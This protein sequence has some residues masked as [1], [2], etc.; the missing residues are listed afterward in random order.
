VVEAT[1]RQC[2]VIFDPHWKGSGTYARKICSVEC[3]RARVRARARG[4]VDRRTYRER[5]PEQV[6]TTQCSQCD[7]TFDQLP[8]VRR[9]RLTCSK[10]CRQE[11]HVARARAWHAANYARSNA[12]NDLARSV[13]LSPAGLRQLGFDI[14]R[15]RQLIAD[16]IRCGNC[17]TDAPPRSGSQPGICL[18]HDHQTGAFRGLLCNRCNL[19]LGFAGDTREGLLS[20]LAYL[21]RAYARTLT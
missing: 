17:G 14:T 7:R 5:H 20:L 13:C 2:G 21:D 10:E 19:A 6:I 15:L 18:D 8:N 3:Q 4:R 1:C 11:R 16:G 9:Y 12:F